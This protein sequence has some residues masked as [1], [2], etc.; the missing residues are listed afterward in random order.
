MQPKAA[1]EHILSKLATELPPHLTY[2]GHHHTVD[3][4]EACER[5]G[6][7]ERL[8]AGELDLVL[9]AAAYHDCGFLHGHQNHE[10]RGC[11][12]A[13]AILPEF[14]FDAASIDHVCKMIMATKVPQQPHDRLSNILC[15]ADLDYL[16]RDDFESI[17]KTLYLE[18]SELN[19]VS[20]EEAWNRIQLKFLENHSYHTD[21]SKEHRETPKALHLKKI[22]AIVAQYDN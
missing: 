2:H 7:A 16:G 1:I 18:L 20:D 6:R 22:R 9:V 21:Y 4:L 12:T 3:V 8:T 13:K 5:I 14:G 10:E 19:I 15:D 17:A 11:E